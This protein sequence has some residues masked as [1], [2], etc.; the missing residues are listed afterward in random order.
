M[1]KKVIVFNCWEIAPRVFRTCKRLGIC[2]GC[3]VLRSGL[4][5][6][7]RRGSFLFEAFLIGPPS[8]KGSYL[9]VD[10][11]LSAIRCG[12]RCGASWVRI[13]AAQS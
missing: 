2:S 9:N 11:M 12:R 1:F 3:R 7:K 8:T 13:L 5:C 4:R 10:A 6:P